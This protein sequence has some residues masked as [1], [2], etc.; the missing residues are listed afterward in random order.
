MDVVQACSSHSCKLKTSGMAS[1]GLEGAQ[2]A[3]VS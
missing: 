1:Y 3:G 2:E